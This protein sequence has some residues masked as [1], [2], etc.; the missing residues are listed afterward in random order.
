MFGVIEV[1]MKV[2]R[3]FLMLFDYFL[4]IVE[5]E[6]GEYDLKNCLLMCDEFGFYIVIYVSDMD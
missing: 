3:L 1:C 6:I 4:I 5:L 2:F